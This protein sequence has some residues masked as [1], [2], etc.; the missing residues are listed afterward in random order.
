M[1]NPE[2]AKAED[3][4]CTVADMET[5]KQEGWIGC[6]HLIATLLFL[7]EIIQAKVVAMVHLMDGKMITKN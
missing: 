3:V 7:V 4:S 6:L 5:L 2:T 1:I